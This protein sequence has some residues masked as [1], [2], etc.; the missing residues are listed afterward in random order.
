MGRH[1]QAI[2]IV[3]IADGANTRPASYILSDCASNPLSAF[4]A[5][6]SSELEAAFEKI[7]GDII[8]LRLAK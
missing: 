3:F 5:D 2:A 6:S 1:S 4:T 8:A 7:G